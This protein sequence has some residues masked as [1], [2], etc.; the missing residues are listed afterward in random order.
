MFCIK[1]FFLMKPLK[2]INWDCEKIEDL[3][4]SLKVYIKKWGSFPFQLVS[5]KDEGIEIFLF[6]FWVLIEIDSTTAS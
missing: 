4:E 6:L 1:I 5:F 2:L 3:T